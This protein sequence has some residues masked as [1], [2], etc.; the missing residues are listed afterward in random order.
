MQALSLPALTNPC[1][2]RMNSRCGMRCIF[3]I[4]KVAWVDRARSRFFFNGGHDE[5][6][7]FK[8]Y[9]TPL[10]RLW[11][12]PQQDEW[13]TTEGGAPKKPPPPPL[14]WGWKMAG[15]G[16]VRQYRAPRVLRGLRLACK[17]A[18]IP[19]EVEPRKGRYKIDVLAVMKNGSGRSSAQRR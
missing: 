3:N 7:Q 10:S 6:Y 11:S 12:W 1:A 16:T 14:A 18:A 9:I 17:G 8:N 13:R 5:I 4:P 2:H 19:Y 15:T